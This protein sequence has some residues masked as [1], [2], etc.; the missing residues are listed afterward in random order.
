MHILNILYFRNRVQI[1]GEPEGLA[2]PWAEPNKLE[3]SV[4]Y[5][6]GDGTV[7]AESLSQCRKWSEQ[8]KGAQQPLIHYDVLAGVKHAAMVTGERAQ[9]K[10]VSEWTSHLVW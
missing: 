9:D 2:E 1:V 7:N 4:K 6:D 8:R 5:G 3:Y 10:V